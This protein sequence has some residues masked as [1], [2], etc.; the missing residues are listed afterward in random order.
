MAS[1][2]F[3]GGEDMSADVLTNQAV[4]LTKHQRPT[5]ELLS[6]A[7]PTVAQMA[8]YTVLQFTD[9]YMLA[10]VGPVQ[11][12][13]A[14]NSGMFSFAFIGFGVGLLT[15]VNTLVSQSYGRRDFQQCGRYLWQGI[16]FS[17]L[18]AVAVLATIPFA[19]LPFL[20]SG[21]EPELVRLE[22][23]FFSIAVLG[24]FMKLAAH[25]MGQFLLATD[26][27]G[28]VLVAAIIG[29]GTNVFTAWVLIFGEF[30]IPAMGVAGAAWG[31]N[32]ALTVEM[33]ILAAF[34]FGP[35]L[36]RTYNAFDWRLRMREMATLL[37]IGFPSGAQFVADILAWTLFMMTVMGAFGTAAMAANTF[38]FRFW[39]VSFMPA[40][41]IATAVTALVG[42]YIGMGKP[43]VAERRAHLGFVISSIY[44]LSCG[45]FFFVARHSLMRLFTDDPEII[46]IGAT[47]LIFAAIY[48]FFDAM[49]IVY[50]GALRGAG[51]TLV[52]AIAVFV[53]C[54]GITVVCGYYVAHTW[55]QYGPKGP[56]MCATIYG[57]L[58][59]IFMFTRFKRG[60]WR[61]IRLESHD[62]KALRPDG[63][64]VTSN[65]HDDSAKLIAAPV[66]AT[67]ASPSSA[68][69]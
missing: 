28:L 37:R 54:W 42:R 32:I 9:T 15:L 58:M 6:I 64:P 25:T 45:V 67:L 62:E 39:V 8:S 23:I 22:A 59:G 61:K 21:H 3:V 24:T 10:R 1:G 43:D 53:L 16:W 35:K 18:L 56:W 7:A 34:T 52:P 12:T 5:I 57:I 4:P 55:P 46:R 60:R 51:D 2:F 17:F 65:V 33:L 20:W 36:A 69:E 29:V 31:T 50:N 68:D 11:A 19:R 13:A 47:V 27:P 38:A 63:F 14:G 49:Y 26:R 41:G 48:Q 40:F 30:G 66:G 44:M